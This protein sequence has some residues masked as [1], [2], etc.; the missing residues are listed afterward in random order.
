MDASAIMTRTVVTVRPDTPVSGVAKTLLENRISAVPV[1]DAGA[2]VGII[3]EGDLLRRAEIGTERHRSR[4]LELAFSN[5]TLAADY[6][7]EHSRKASDVMTR[8]VVTVAPATPV[9]EITKILESRHIK[10]VPVL[11]D[12]K[13]VGIVS[14][15]NLI[16]A[17]ASSKGG[18]QPATTPRDR[19]IQ[20][21]LHQEMRK[22][23]W[24]VSP[25][26]ANV[27]V[28][29]GEVHLWGYIRSEEAR[30][31]MVIAAEN[32]PGVRRVQDHME[33]PPVYPPF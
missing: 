10:R 22:Q 30:R 26:D 23:R 1:L 9:T 16:Q 8:D 13:L 32:V 4:W 25:I 18:P 11:A 33:Y 20:E 6:A 31:A 24:A 7:K 21:A 27:V 14:R 5:A 17:L 28:R 12:D 19:E 15:A 29:D 2:L 3:S